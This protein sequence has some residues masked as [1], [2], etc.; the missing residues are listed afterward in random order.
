L[1]SREGVWREGEREEMR[2]G[3]REGMRDQGGKKGGKSWSQR[4]RGKREGERARLDT[5]QAEVR[6][7]VG[8]DVDDGA[9]V[10]G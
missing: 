2:E 6:P 10:R 9:A 3:R 7:W 8:T 5:L 1:G 4:R